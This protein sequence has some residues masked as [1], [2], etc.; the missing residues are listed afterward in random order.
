MPSGYTY[1]SAFSS[2]TSRY[3]SSG[4]VV[5][6]PSFSQFIADAQAANL[7]SAVFLEKPDADEKPESD[8]NIQS[9]VAETRQLINAVM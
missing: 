1:A 5:T 4:N 7:P 6:D 2:F 8:N 3:G 9:G